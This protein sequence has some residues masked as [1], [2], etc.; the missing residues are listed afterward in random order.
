MQWIDP[1]GTTTALRVLYDVHGRFAP[2]SRRQEETLPGQPGGA[3]REV[4]H[5]IREFVLPV[6]IH[7]S[8]AT[9]LRTTLRDL[10]LAMDPVRGDGAIRV[11]APGGDQREITCRVAAGL[12]LDEVLGDTATPTDQIAT[13][14]FRAV[15]PYWSAT[16]DTVIDYEFESTTVSFFPIFPIRLASSEVFADDTVTVTGD[17]QSWPVWVITGP[18]STINVKNLTTGK[19]TTLSTTALEAGE[20]VTID[21]RPGAK[22]V[23]RQDG[24]SLFSDLSGSL[25]PLL[26]GPNAVRVEMGGAGTGSAVSLRYRP[27]YLTP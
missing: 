25:W 9:E 10:A 20:Y 21:T 24:T 8:T 14:V 22:T 23:T 1:D 11:T 13:V 5:D 12:D 27:R 6:H 3:L 16:S 4:L 18:G 7:G 15:D 2:P 19:A 17:V 26:R